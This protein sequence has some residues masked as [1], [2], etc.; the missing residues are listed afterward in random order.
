MTSKQKGQVMIG[1]D[2]VVIS[3]ATRPD[4]Y[5]GFDDEG[6][7]IPSDKPSPIP[8]SFFKTSLLAEGDYGGSQQG[9]SPIHKV[10]DGVGEEW[11]LVK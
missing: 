6:K 9:W 11:E 3:L 10:A 8:F 2:Q 7:L 5:V 4:L 1:T